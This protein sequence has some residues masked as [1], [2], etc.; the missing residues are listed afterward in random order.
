MDKIEL[1]DYVW[2]SLPFS[3]P[4]SG[5]VISIKP[6]IFG[7]RYLIEYRIHNLDYDYHYTAITWR[8]WW[9]IWK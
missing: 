4:W 9:R 7:N 6:T 2:L 5:R 1:D 3:N 8:M